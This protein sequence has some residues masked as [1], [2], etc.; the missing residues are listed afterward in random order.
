MAHQ[1]KDNLVIYGIHPVEE[2][3]GN[4]DNVEKIFV[5]DDIA[6]QGI[7]EIIK[8]SRGL[9]IPCFVVPSQKLDRISNTRNHQG[10]VA[11]ISPVAYGDIENLIPDIIEKGESPKIMVLD[12]VT[13]VRNFGAIARTALFLGFHALVIPA[14]GNA[15]FNDEAVKASAGALLKIPVCRTHVLKQAVF[16]MKHSGLRIVGASEK[17]EKPVWDCDLSAPIAL[18]MGS[19]DEGISHSILKL[20]DEHI[21]IPRSGDLDSLNVS[22]AAGIL[23]Y[24]VF[25]QSQ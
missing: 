5:K 13:D 4:P 1:N 22:V 9:K 16:F 12:G 6:A 3:L 23:A 10:V 2:A 18:V 8:K 11:Y 20:C 17:A 24:E 21:Q 14:R 7:K 15:R 19:E 25:K